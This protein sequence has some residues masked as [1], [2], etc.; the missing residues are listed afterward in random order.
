MEELRLSS[1]TVLS[2]SGRI[3]EISILVLLGTGMAPVRTIS[4]VWL[5]RVEAKRK[6]FLKET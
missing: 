4:R 6:Y 1:E 3:K 5:L 2:I